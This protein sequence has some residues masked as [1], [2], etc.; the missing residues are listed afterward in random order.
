MWNDRPG[1][2]SVDPPGA[3][4]IG[5]ISGDRHVAA[6]A[7][8]PSTRP[9]TPSHRPHP[10]RPTTESRRHPGLRAAVGLVLVALLAC[11]VERGLPE[12]DSASDPAPAVAA[13]SL[14][15]LSSLQEV[16]DSVLDLEYR[17]LAFY[18]R[19]LQDFGPVRPFS[20]AAQAEEWHV[21]ALMRLYAAHSLPVPP[22]RSRERMPPHASVREA[23]SEA[24]LGERAAGRYYERVLDGDLPA[25]VRAVLQSLARSSL[26]R[27]AVAFERCAEGRP[28]PWGDEDGPGRRRR[29]RGSGRR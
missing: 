3:A 12:R 18:E 26:E 17:A 23:C 22:D 7:K 13:D 8:P 11:D 1:E 9:R 4:L 6:E 20:H 28:P 29:G 19:A 14:G 16:L 2:G 10:D 21:R 5:V 25:D 24:V 15:T 27:H